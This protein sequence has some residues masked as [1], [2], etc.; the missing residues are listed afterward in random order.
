[1]KPQW[2]K[3][4]PPKQD[5]F[6]NIK[7]ILREHSLNTVCEEAHC[8]NMSE[9]WSGGT[10]TFMIMGD[11]CTR[12]CKFCAVKTGFPAKPL[13]PGEPEN[14]AEAISK[15][16]LD[17]VV[18]TSVDR[19]DLKDQGA[20]HFAKCVRRIKE[21]KNVLVEVLIPDF[22]GNEECIQQIIDSGPDVIA[23]NIET[24]RRLQHPVRD[25]RARYEQSLKVLK[26]VKEK[27]EK[28]FTKS[29]IMVGLG[30]KKEEVLEAMRDLRK[31]N[32][33]MLTIG[34]YLRPSSWH[35]EVK[36]YVA[37]ETFNYYERVGR[38]MGFMYVASGP[39]VRSSYKAGELFVKSVLKKS[40]KQ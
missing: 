30:E 8:P 12:A 31:N 28:I 26:F 13:N 21:K 22:K 17:Y 35:S 5:A 34:Q 15:M 24:I 18:I 36:E 7:S 1:M 40:D 6:P 14:L 19:D 11:T 3:I 20:G 39:F 33:D 25:P 29:S 38:K 10:A 16:E 32:V 9:C 4:R 23:H 37:P 2:L 27:D